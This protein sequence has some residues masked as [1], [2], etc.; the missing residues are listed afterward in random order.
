MN[1]LAHSYLSYS[2][3]Q[4]VGN[5]LVDF[6][7]RKDRLSY[8]REIQKGIDLH[9]AIDRFTDSHPKFK[10]IKALFRPLTGHYAGV[11]ADI[12]L[13]YFILNDRRLH[14]TAQWHTHCQWAYQSLTQYE[15][16]LPPR[17]KSALPSMIRD[18]WL[19]QYQSLEGMRKSL[20]HV[21]RRAEF[22]ED[23]VNVFEV[24]VQ[25]LDRIKKLY[26]AFF[27]ELKAYCEEFNAGQS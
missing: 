23:S 27:P 1:Y 11:F 15:E 18:N 14:S 8:P 13:D 19:M 17:L 3:E 26:D 22:L 20:H 7:K 12:V 25:N 16:W 5:L 9:H 10:A 2:P 21:V 4:L 24:L 6:A